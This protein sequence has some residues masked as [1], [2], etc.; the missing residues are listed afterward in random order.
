MD[1]TAEWC[2]NC[3]ALEQTVLYRPRVAEL[4]N[5]EGVSAIKVDLTGNNT[6]G[7]AMLQK[8]NRLTIPLL[9]VFAPDGTEV[10]KGDF[11]TVDQVIKAVE[12]AR[13]GQVA[14]R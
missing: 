13:N 7:K 3:K 1:F 5:S 2:L 12:Q 6:T 14:A 10:F 8:V 9:V 4:L 11:Y